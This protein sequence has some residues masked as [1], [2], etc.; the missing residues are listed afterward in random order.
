MIKREE[1][2]E[3]IRDLNLTLAEEYD[4]VNREVVIATDINS[5]WRNPINYHVD[6]L[7]KHIEID[8]EVISE[9]YPYMDAEGIRK[10][11]LDE[12]RSDRYLKHIFESEDQ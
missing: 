1:F 10:R 12:I 6:H 4:S 3:I 2:N 7:N 11:L 5:V 9:R 8:Y